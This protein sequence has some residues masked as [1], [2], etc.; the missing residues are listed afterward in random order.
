ML[1]VFMRGDFSLHNDLVARQRRENVAELHL[2]GAVAARG[3]KMVYAEFKR[4]ADDR[5]E[6][7]LVV[8]RNRGRVNVLPFILITHPAAGYDGHPDFRAAKATIFHARQ[9]WHAFVPQAMLVVDRRRPRSRSRSRSF[10][11]LKRTST[12]T[13]TIT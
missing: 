5:F 2:G 11:R 9:I 8:A 3:F 10:F 13:R 6:V 4:A 12:R 1:R 7:L